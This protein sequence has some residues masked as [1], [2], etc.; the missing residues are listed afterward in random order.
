VRSDGGESDEE[1]ARDLQKTLSAQGRTTQQP[2]P[3]RQTMRHSLV[4]TWLEGWRWLRMPR[5]PRWTRSMV[6]NRRRH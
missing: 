5:S 2:E 1:F 4:L 3:K 6:R